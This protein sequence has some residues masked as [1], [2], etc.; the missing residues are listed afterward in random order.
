MIDKE[1]EERLQ[2][3]EHSKSENLESFP[4]KSG[5][6]QGSVFP[7]FLLNILLKAR[8]NATEKKRK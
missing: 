5:S 1:Y 4:L 3:T 2:Q 6:G 7:L 8:A